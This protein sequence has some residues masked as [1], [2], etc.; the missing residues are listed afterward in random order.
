[1]LEERI[2]EL[3][4]TVHLLRQL[5]IESEYSTA[6]LI[7]EKIARLSNDFV[8]MEEAEASLYL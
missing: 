6:R 1:M 7:D 8:T 2:E 3:E 5:I 4:H